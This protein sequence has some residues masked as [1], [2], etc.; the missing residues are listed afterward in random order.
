MRC[1][2]L[3]EGVRMLK[4]DTLLELGQ[5]WREFAA[6]SDRTDDLFF[7]SNESDIDTKKSC[8]P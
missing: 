2:L 1:D 8:D 3:T 5:E 4:G 7:P 6:C